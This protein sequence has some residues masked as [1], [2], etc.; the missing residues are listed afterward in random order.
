MDQFDLAPVLPKVTCIVHYDMMCDV[1]CCDWANCKTSTDLEFISWIYFMNKCPGVRPI[2]VGE[3]CR[4]IVG[5]VV[6]MYSKHDLRQ[7][8]GPLQLCG[9]FESGCE[10]AFHAMSEIIQ[11]DDT[12]AMLFVDVTNAFNNLNRQ[13]TLLNSQIVCPTLA[14]SVIN[15]YRNPSELFV[16]GELPFF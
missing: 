3:V 15:T 14:P 7:A 11:E 10:A 2:G 6:M 4:R 9:G 8:V 12:E 13:V 16:D 1:M 5:K